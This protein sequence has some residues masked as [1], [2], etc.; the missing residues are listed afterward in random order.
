MFKQQSCFNQIEKLYQIIVHLIHSRHFRIINCV[1]LELFIFSI[2]LNIISFFN[3]FS[4]FIFVFKCNVLLYG[5]CHPLLNVEFRK[6]K[7]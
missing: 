5:V 7:V 2:N 1:S 4:I 3:I 6:R